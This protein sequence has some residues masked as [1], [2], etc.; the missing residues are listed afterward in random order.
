MSQ[1]EEFKTLAGIS[2]EGGMAYNKNL[3]LVILIRA[4]HTFLDI[5]TSIAPLLTTQPT[6]TTYSAQ[7]KQHMSFLTRATGVT[8]DENV[9]QLYDDW[10]T[11]YDE[12][13]LNASQDYVAPALAAQTVLASLGTATIARDVAILDAGCGTGLVGVHLAKLGAGP[14][15]GVDLSAGMLEVARKTGAYGEL[16]VADLSKPLEV[17][18]GKYDVV[19]CVGTLT[20]GHVGPGVL[21]EFVRV[22]RKGGLVVATVRETVWKEQGFDE[23]VK[24]LVADGQVQLMGAELEEYRRGAAAKAYM[25]RLK[26]AS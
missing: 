22:V 10:A 17:A 19:T 26:V 20:Q 12:D 2:A 24:R 3:I 14:V 7:G 15:D 6:H 4:P 16:H 5:S 1:P 18:D 25:V 8:A 23:E 11:T 13:M 21:R 9:A